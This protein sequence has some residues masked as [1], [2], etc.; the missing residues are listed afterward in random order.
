IVLDYTPLSSGAEGERKAQVFVVRRDLVAAYQT[1]CQTAGLKLTGLTPR[2]HGMAA[3]LRSLLGTSVLVPNPEPADAAVALV[4]VG[5]KWAE[6]AII[7][8]NALLQTRTLTV[9]P[10]LAGEIR[11]NLVVYAGQQSQSP[12]KAVYLALSGDQSV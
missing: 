10:G 12:V 11:R 7:K 3:C 1:L 4:T 6:F 8:G 5:E 9:G 2:P